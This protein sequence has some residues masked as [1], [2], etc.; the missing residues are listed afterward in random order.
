MPLPSGTPPSPSTTSRLPTPPCRAISTASPLRPSTCTGSCSPDGCPTS[1]S[2]YAK[3]GLKACRGMGG[4]PARPT[5]PER[6]H[7]H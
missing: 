3:R 7:R 5:A 1:S 4:N 6:L 2:G